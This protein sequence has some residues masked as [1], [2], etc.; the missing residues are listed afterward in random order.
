MG[1]KLH[2]LPYFPFLTYGNILQM[3]PAL[4]TIVMPV[5]HYG[6]ATFS[7]IWTSPYQYWIP[8]HDLKVWIT[9]WFSPRLPTIV[10]PVSHYGFATFSWIWTSPYQYWIPAQDLKVWITWWFSPRLPTFFYLYLMVCQ[11][12]R[13]VFHCIEDMAI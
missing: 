9:W 2:F 10:M 11:S 5:S 4:P 6:F 3:F 7:W 1:N 13:H 12:C 8:A